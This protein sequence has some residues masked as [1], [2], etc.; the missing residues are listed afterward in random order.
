MRLCIYGG[1]Y[2]SEG[3]GSVAEYIA[4]NGARTFKKQDDKEKMAKLVAIGE[5][6]PNSGHTCS[7]GKTRNMPAVSYF[8]DQVILGPD[9]AVSLGVLLGDLANI[10]A[11]VGKTPRIY[12]HE[13]AAFVCPE[14]EKEER[15]YGLVERISSTGSGSGAS[16]AFH[17]Y[18]MRELDAV[19]RTRSITG[20]TD[21]GYEV[22][23][24]NRYQYQELI[25][26]IIT[27]EYDCLMECSQGTLLDTNWGIYPYVTSK[28]TLPRVAVE[29]NALGPLGFN[30]VGVYR[31][32]PIRTGGPSGPTGAAE[33]TF[34]KIGVKDEIA[35]VT[36]RVRR[37]FEFSRD[38]FELSINLTRPWV[39]A[40]THLDYI[41]V[42]PDN[43]LGFM[44]W[45][46]DAM[47]GPG[48]LLHYRVEGL[49]LSDETGKFAN[50]QQ[51]EL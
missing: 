23:V 12:I 37:V 46:I 31:T 21:Q 20:L 49:L 28:S 44:R 51:Q 2:G 24:V 18:Y 40:F 22:V 36:K 42:K 41:G 26:S 15:T 7:L 9:S 16:R 43:L 10:K 34:A 13:H 25:R 27:E 6:S 1:Q 50:H 17:K 5:N 30:Y 8:A 19:I 14:H 47:G 3:K 45:Y 38:D 32:Y 33:T 11:A 35:T 4:R 39:V 48:S 29:R